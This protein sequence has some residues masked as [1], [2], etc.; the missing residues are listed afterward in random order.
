MCVGP[1]SGSSDDATFL[2]A[3]E[4]ADPCFVQLLQLRGKSLVGGADDSGDGRL[5]HHG[6]V[7][8][9]GR[10]AFCDR[11][12]ALSRVL[13][14]P[15]GWNASGPWRGTRGA[16]CKTKGVSELPSDIYLSTSSGSAANT[17]P[18]TDAAR[19]LIA[20]GNGLRRRRSRA[21]AEK[22][23]VCDNLTNQSLRQ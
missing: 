11:I 12:E 22:H 19:R 7:E 13:P 8:F 4:I 17:L 20:R 14:T 9:G 16:W 15:A 3:V 18:G 23:C 5:L 10:L 6:W 1:A 21:H 2:H